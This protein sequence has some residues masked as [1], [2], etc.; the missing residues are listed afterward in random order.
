MKPETNKLNVS[1]KQWFAIAVIAGAVFTVS[2]NRS[3]RA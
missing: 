2:W 1:K 3:G